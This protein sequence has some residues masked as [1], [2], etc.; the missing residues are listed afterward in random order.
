MMSEPLPDARVEQLISCLAPLADMVRERG[1]PTD[2]AL[3]VL[4]QREELNEETW[5]LDELRRWARFLQQAA[6]GKPAVAATVV[7]ALK[8][9]NVPEASASLAVQAVFDTPN[10]PASA[11]PQPQP[12][13]S[14]PIRAVPEVLDFGELEPG[15]G[16]HGQFTASGGP[17]TVRWSSDLLDV[18][19]ISF[20]PANTH[21]QVT[22]QPGQDGQ[23]L[24]DELVLL[25]GS[26]TTRVAV[27]ARW[28]RH[29]L[30]Q[31]EPVVTQNEDLALPTA[32]VVREPVL[33]GNSGPC[34]T[35]NT[36]LYRASAEYRQAEEAFKS[37]HARAIPLLRPL[38]EAG[39]ARA[40]YMLARM[41]IRSPAARPEAFG[42]F[43]KS[44]EQNDP[45]G[46]IGLGR[47]F[48]EG[49]ST[50]KWLDE[51]SKWFEE[52][53]PTLRS[54]AE[55][56]DALA[57]C[58]LALCYRMG[59]G[60][61]TNCKEA[62]DW[63]R[64]AA[65]QGHAGAQYYLG[66]CYENGVG[67]RKDHTQAVEWYRKAAEQ[68]DADAQN[69][70]GWCYENGVGVR[71]DHTQAFEWYRKAAEQGHADAQYNLG[72]CYENGVGVRKDH[73]Q[74]VEWYRKAA[75]QGD[76]DAQYN[77]GV[78]YEAGRGVAKDDVQALKWY[79]AAADQELVDAQYNLGRCYENGVGVARDRW[80]AAE[81]YRKAAGKGFAEAQ[82]SL[83]RCCQY[84]LDIPKDEKQAAEWYRKAA[85][86]GHADAQ[87]CLGYCYRHGVGIPKDDAQAVRWYR[88]AAE[89]GHAKAQYNLGLRHQLGR[90]VTKDGQQAAK[91]YRK[92]AVQGNADAQ[93]NLG[94]CY[95]VGLGVTKDDQQAVAWYRSAAELGSADAQ[96]NLGLCYENGRGVVKD[97]ALA[98]YWYRKAAEQGHRDAAEALKRVLKRL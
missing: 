72:V 33:S 46:M 6:Q 80:R 16:A 17:G 23:L 41:L 38:A 18:K 71:K 90:G 61:S 69:N 47:C 20:G 26:E 91:W 86:Q 55:S 54:A 7:Q 31:P 35:P 10:Q 9:R 21:I 88:K 95:Q 36:A 94:Y 65:E 77:L 5:A 68:G 64:K 42:W 14:S 66:W 27:T 13:P 75:E 67:V 58:D 51:A 83:G 29:P 84:G 53:L 45:C 98:A 97:D 56:G 76:A 1:M 44:A 79:R 92:A 73:K 87:Y 59:L 40:Q 70:L 85:E 32:G 49:W 34:G 96:Y 22:L 50:D 15:N 62:V 11:L 2:E 48:A 19:P 74:A 57:Q 43:R 52:S 37:G 28:V 93:N 81:W 82:Y 8:H 24:W 60:V 12:V 78:C 30:A 63:Y 3:Q 25:N 39:D 4:L 89:Q